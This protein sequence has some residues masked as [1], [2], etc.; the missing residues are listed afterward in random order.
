MKI[1]KARLFVSTVAQD[2]LETALR[3]G[4][5]LEIA[6]FCTAMNM[7]TNFDVWDNLVRTNIAGFDRVAFHAPFNELCPAAI[8]PKIHAIAFERYLQSAELAHTYGARRMVVHSGYVPLVYFKGYFHERSVEFWKRVLA[9]IPEDMTLLLENVLEDE[10]ALLAG[11][12]AE[13]A[14]PRLRLC[15]D[16]GHANTI[17]SEMPM[18][19]WITVSAPHIG[20]LHVHNNF[21]TWDDHNPPGDGLIDMH[22]A[23]TRLLAEIP[24]EATITLESIESAPAAKWL[25]DNGYLA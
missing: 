15:L 7:D 12:V 16:V 3:H 20:H 11:I 13:V 25:Q 23:L 19:E 8:D 14:D 18:D 21:R 17:V 5:G 10:P 4:L 6:E 22:R 1:D 2:A 9:E 24:A